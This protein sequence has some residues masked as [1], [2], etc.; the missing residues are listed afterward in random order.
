MPSSVL[1]LTLLLGLTRKSVEL[2][3]IAVCRYPEL[4]HQHFIWTF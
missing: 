2:D 4:H 1:R 3:A